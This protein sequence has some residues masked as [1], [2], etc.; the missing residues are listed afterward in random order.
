MR[1]FRD[2][3][4]KH[5]LTLIIMLIS[6]VALLLS[7]TLFIIYDL[8]IERREMMR[9][10]LTQAD[11]IGN[12]STAALSFND[13]DSATE[14][15]AALKAKPEIIAACLYDKEGQ[16]FAIYRRADQQGFD[17][18]PPVVEAGGNQFAGDRLR[19]FRQI[20][21]E[22][23]VIGTVC[24]ESD[25]ERLYERRQNFIRIVGVILLISAG[26]AFLLSA[27][28]RRVISEPIAD[29]AQTAKRVSVFEQVNLNVFWIANNFHWQS[30]LALFEQTLR[31]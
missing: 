26:V 9:D 15:L 4:I 14:M 16:L 7:C 17:F 10:L 25:V 2:L 1:V 22:E 6:I 29:L 18:L 12:H 31:D 11:I 28:L 21:M 13:V 24:L 3:S 27:R 30:L 5:K 23:T 19:L 8:G 20:V